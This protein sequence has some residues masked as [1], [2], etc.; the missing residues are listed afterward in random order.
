[1]SEGTGGVTESIKNRLIMPLTGDYASTDHVLGH[2][3]VHVFQYDIAFADEDTIPFKVNALPL[4]LIEGMAE[5]FSVGR[6][7]PHT[8]MWL[9]D[10]LLS[11]DFP[12]IKQLTTDSRFFPYRFGQASGPTWRALGDNVIPEIYKIAGRRAWSSPLPASWG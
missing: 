5:Y 7:D 1:L 2:E 8:A 10:A 12:T 4:W 6:H 3:M 9:R 11:K